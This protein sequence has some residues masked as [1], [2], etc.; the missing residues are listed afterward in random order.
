MFNSLDVIVP[1]CGERN[2]FNMWYAAWVV[3]LGNALKH[4]AFV[5]AYTVEDLTECELQHIL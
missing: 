2:F 1:S 4:L 3:G 5:V